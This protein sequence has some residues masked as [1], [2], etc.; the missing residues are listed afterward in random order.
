MVHN[1]SSGLIWT[2][3]FPEVH[4]GAPQQLERHSLLSSVVIV[5]KRQELQLS[6]QFDLPAKCSESV[7]K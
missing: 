1:L 4:Y 2:L 5:S 7:G 3:Q 6:I